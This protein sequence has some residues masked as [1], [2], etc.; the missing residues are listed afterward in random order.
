MF[1]FRRKKSIA[2]LLTICFLFV[3]VMPGYAADSETGADSCTVGV[4]IVDNEGNLI[5][6]SKNVKVQSSTE[7]GMTAL[8]ALHATGVPYETKDYG[9]LGHMVTS[10]NGLAND[11][12]TWDGWKLAVND[13]G[14][15]QSADAYEIKEGDHFVWYYGAFDADPPE[16]GSLQ[17]PDIITFEP[18]SITL[19]KDET[20]QVE[21]VLNYVNGEKKD[22]TDESEWTV[23]DSSIASVD[24]GLITAL[25]AGTTFIS[26]ALDGV[27]AQL[28]VKVNPTGSTVT[29]NIAIVGKDGELIYAPGEITV[30]ES[31]DWGLTAL[32][33]L[34]ATGVSYEVEEY[35]WGPYVTSINGQ[36]GD[37]NGGWL[38][39]VND[40]SPLVGMHQYDLQDGDCIIIYNSTDWQIPGPTWEG[41]T[42]QTP[43]DS[44]PDPEPEPGTGISIAP[45]EALAEVI[46]YYRNNKTTLNSWAEV[47][48]LRSAGVDLTDGSW[49]LPDWKIDELNEDS[50]ATDFAG[51][52]IG[53]LAAGQEPTDVDGRNLVQE[54]VDRQNSDG[55]FGD[56][57]NETIWSMIA[58]DT[59]K[60]E[61]DVSAAVKY[62]C[63]QQLDDGGF[64]LFGTDSDPDMTGMVLIALAPHKD[65]EGV[66]AVM[67]DAV[68][69]LKGLQQESGG[70]ASWGEE[71][72]ESAAAVTRGLVAVGIDPNTMAK[73]GNTVFA[74]LM[75]YQLGDKSFSHIKG[76][77]SDPMATSQALTAIGDIVYGNVFARIRDSYTPGEFEKPGGTDQPTLPKTGGENLLF[78]L[79]GATLLCAGTLMVRRKQLNH[80]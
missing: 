16:W 43:P 46:S 28:V 67:N 66:S 54:L 34:D 77:K 6:G 8:G 58:L 5:F 80:K 10:I 22:V 25:K 76:G 73:N 72:A 60:A 38:Y 64:A 33:A 31:G 35:D 47:V 3:M 14:A 56:W 18:S 24:K 30:Q 57:F 44:D 15:T 48:A 37:P 39:T 65:I 7:Y 45:S 12:E 70:F 29:V 11:P 9:S 27:T 49:K 61:Y 21:A 68:E 13:E 50:Y 78:Y 42:G 63:D 36:A 79:A 1:R 32:G 55:S 41:L 59:A 74:A 2:L 52:I 19:E 62:L 69:C 23:E 40:E 26:A 53:M 17:I 71:C 75:S 51:T 4:A 20:K